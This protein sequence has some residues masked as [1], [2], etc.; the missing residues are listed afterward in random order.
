MH[1]HGQPTHSESNMN[2]ILLFITKTQWNMCE[3][4]KNI[5]S[6]VKGRS[7]SRPFSF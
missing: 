7:K 3:P 4:F 6:Q 5:I 2:I 1:L